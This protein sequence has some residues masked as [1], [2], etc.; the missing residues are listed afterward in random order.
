MPF[1]SYLALDRLSA[2]GAKSIL[3]AP[4]VYQ[5]ER[6]H[7]FE[8]TAA[9][10]LGTL[11]HRLVLERDAGDY[12]IIEGGYGKGKR[13]ADV[14]ERGLIPV[15]QE[16]WD[17]AHNMALAVDEHPL[18]ADLLSVG[19]PEQTILWDQDG[20]PMKARMDWVRDG[21]VVDLK[22]TAS[23]NPNDFRRSIATFGYHVQQAVYEAA[24]AALNGTAPRFVF[25]AVESRAPHLVS[26][27][28][29]DEEAVGRGRVLMDRAVDLYR[30]CTASGE[31]PGYSEI[32][33]VSLPQWA[34]FDQDEEEIII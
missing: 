22:T 15:T 6:T 14:R 18:A 24:Y 27:I 1:D 23:A 30:E 31:W 7:P 8:P 2:S 25:V 4:A 33:R 9:M 20:V 11:V 17:T 19:E 16:T 5:Y 12:E 10:Q 26:V 21:V 34:L 29:L 32:N 13:E 3:R 28:E